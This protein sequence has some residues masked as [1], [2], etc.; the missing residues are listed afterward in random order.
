MAKHQSRSLRTFGG[1]WLVPMTW[2]AAA[3]PKRQPSWAFSGQ[4]KSF[5]TLTPTRLL[6][7]RVFYPGPVDPMVAC[8]DLSSLPSL[9]EIAE[10]RRTRLSER[11][12]N[13]SCGRRSKTS[14][15]SW[16]SF[17]RNMS[18]WF[19]SMLPLSFWEEWETLTLVE[20]RTRL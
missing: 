3:A 14:T 5:I 17:A 15:R 4:P 20:T 9:V 11:K 10:A 6:L 16:K 7:S 1:S 12:R 13:S 19:T 2:V 18:T 8:P